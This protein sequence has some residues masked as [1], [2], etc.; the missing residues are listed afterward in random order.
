MVNQPTIVRYII[1]T[2]VT[3]RFLRGHRR[4]GALAVVGRAGSGS[5][6]ALR[7]GLASA[8]TTGVVVG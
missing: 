6:V 7:K 2:Q 3:D 5:R 1:R 4:Q 8:S